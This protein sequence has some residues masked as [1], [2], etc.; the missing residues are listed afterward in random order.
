M[1]WSIPSRP[2]C[3]QVCASGG[4]HA[5]PGMSGGQADLEPSA[6]QPGTDGAFAPGCRPSDCGCRLQQLAAFCVFPGG[7]SANGRTDGTYDGRAMTSG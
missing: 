2:A 6:A 5:A 1:P 7:C 3:P 4:S